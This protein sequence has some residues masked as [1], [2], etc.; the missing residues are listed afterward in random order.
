MEVGALSR[1]SDHILQ[2]VLY[3]GLC[4]ELKHIAQYNR[5]KIK[6]RTL[7]V[8]MRTP[9]SKIKTCRVTQNMQKEEKN[10]IG[11]LADI[12]QQLSEKV[13]KLQKEKDAAN[14][15][16]YDQPKYMYGGRRFQRGFGG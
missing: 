10:E 5:F 8:E 6:L 1:R 3:Q 7:E 2:Q 4:I 16:Q 12:V 14:Q 9:D 13:D 15:N 11:A